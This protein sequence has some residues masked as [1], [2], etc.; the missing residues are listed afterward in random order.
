VLDADRDG[1]LSAHEIAMAPMRLAALDLND[2]GLISPSERRT[3]NAEGQPVRAWHGATAA[4]IVLTLDANQ[5]GDL[6]WL[7]ITNAVS[8]LKRLDLNGDGMLTPDELRPATFARVSAA[9]K[10]RA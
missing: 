3:T 8:S 9:A 4:N 1:T 5:D 10:P 2:D 6:Q 7:E